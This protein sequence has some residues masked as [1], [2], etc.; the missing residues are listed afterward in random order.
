AEWEY[1]EAE[2]R[3]A[4]AGWRGAA[5]VGER[6]DGSRIDPA[7]K[8]YIDEVVQGQARL[9]NARINGLDGLA[10]TKLDVLDG[11]KELK[12]CTAYQ[13]AGGEIDYLPTQ[14]A[15]QAEA[16]PVYE[17][18]DG[19]QQSTKGARSWAELPASAV[20]YIRRIEELIEAPVALL[21]TSPERDDTIL[22]QDPFAD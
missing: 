2:G 16:R 14:A 1:V 15:Q 22:V 17:S 13:I 9:T 4:E 6:V 20:K 3:V 18:F 5:P 10:L 8:A 12:V 7:L 19:W 21:S 11:M